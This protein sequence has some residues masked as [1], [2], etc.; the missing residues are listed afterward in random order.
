MFFVVCFV[1]SLFPHPPLNFSFGSFYWLIFELT[2]SL[3]GCAQFN[4]ASKAFFISVTIDSFLKFFLYSYI[5]CMFLHVNFF[6][7]KALNNMN[8]SYFKLSHNSNVYHLW[9]W[10]WCLLYLVRL[11]FSSFLVCLLI[12]CLKVKVWCWV[13]GTEVNKPV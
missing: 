1:F 4:E 12:L 6:F 8:H 3:L 2:D 13:I 5:A 9:V 10:F 7:I 11:F